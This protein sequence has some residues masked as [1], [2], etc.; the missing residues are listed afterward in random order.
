MEAI[1]IVAALHDENIKKCLFFNKN[2]ISL[3]LS[4]QVFQLFCVFYNFLAQFSFNYF[5]VYIDIYWTEKWKLKISN[6]LPRKRTEENVL[7]MYSEHISRAML[8]CLGDG[9]WASDG[10]VAVSGLFSTISN[11]SISLNIFFNVTFLHLSSAKALSLINWLNSCVL[12][13]VHKWGVHL[14][15][16][17]Y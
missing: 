4:V 1:R 12:L 15:S 2:F 5:S 10:T 16:Q 3:F 8:R 11:S 13:N 7:N 14:P 9:C 17:Y 6:L